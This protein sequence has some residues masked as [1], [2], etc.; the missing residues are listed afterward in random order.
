MTFDQISTTHAGSLP[1]TPELISANAA[2]TF[3]DDGFTLERTPEFELLLTDA[4][5]DLVQRQ[6][7]LG[8]TIP[9]DGE[10]GKAMSSPVD[11]GAWWTYSFQR[12]AGLELTDFNPIT[13]GPV[14]SEAGNI[15]LTSFADRR[16]WT[17]FAAAYSDPESGIQLGRNATA[18]PTA[19]GPITYTGHDALAT[20]IANLKAGLAAA[21]LPT[22][23]ITALSPGSAS[24]IG[25][26]YYKSE[27]EF[28]Y[29]WA[30]VLREE[31]KAI[32][33]AGLT[34]QIDDPSIAENWDQINPEPSVED[35]RRFTQIRIDAL[36]Y[37]LRGIPQ[38]QVRFHVCWGSWHGPHTTDIEFANIVDLV[39]GINAGFYAFEAGNARHEHEW[40]IW[41]DVALPEGKVLVP[42]V[43]SHATNVVEHPELVAQRIERFA[44]LVGSGNVIAG[45][46]CGLGGRLHP[47][48]AFAKL[49]SL[50]RGAEIAASRLF[51]GSRH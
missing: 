46:D 49:E 14:R 12:T 37:A 39:L 11:Y 24:R 16:D 1:R 10:Y 34:V 27:E 30:D 44:G 21:D 28:I 19:T 22:G 7:S 40:T 13:T 5:I 36:N 4:V 9:G 25:N 2:R 48:I 3:A 31:Y 41:R 23:F 18:F 47:D 38:E 35:Y 17:R 33:D 8:I 43:V 32:T 26:D 50:G 51:T 29:A 15:R 20:D 42:G 6:K 45:T